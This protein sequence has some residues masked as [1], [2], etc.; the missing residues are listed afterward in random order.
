MV[1]YNIPTNF[2]V[3]NAKD[4]QIIGGSDKFQ[5]SDYYLV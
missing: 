1:S 2:M 4:K 3:P 5:L